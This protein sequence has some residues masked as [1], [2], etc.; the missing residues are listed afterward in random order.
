MSSEKT[1]SSADMVSE[2][3]FSNVGFID[4]HKKNAA[5]HNSPS[6]SSQIQEPSVMI[7]LT[8]Y[9]IKHFQGL[10]SLAPLSLTYSLTLDIPRS[11]AK[12]SQTLTCTTSSA[13]ASRVEHFA[14]NFLLHLRGC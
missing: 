1:T 4:D 5:S 6:K 7:S 2:C 9:K 14:P 8:Q 3:H 12:S 13:Y 10:Q 11:V